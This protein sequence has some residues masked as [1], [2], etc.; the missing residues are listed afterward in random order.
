MLFSEW[1]TRRLDDMGR[2]AASQLART[3]HR[4]PQTVSDYKSGKITPEAW[5]LGQIAAFFHFD[6]TALAEMANRD[7]LEA[8]QAYLEHSWPLA[9]TSSHFLDEAYYQL[10]IAYTLRDRGDPL[11]ALDLL[12][13]WVGYIEER[14]LI[15]Q[16]NTR[17][18]KRRVKDLQA[19]LLRSLNDRMRSMNDVIPKSEIV[20]RTMDDFRLAVRLAQKIGHTREEAR[21]YSLRA[22]AYFVAWRSADA[23]VWV[24]KYL[25]TIGDLP[26]HVPGVRVSLLVPAYL[27]NPVQFEQAE[28]LSL[29]LI[30][31]GKIA[32]A[33][34]LSLLL[35]AMGHGRGLLHLPQADTRLD[36]AQQEFERG[37]A[38]G[39]TLPLRGVQIIRSRLIGETHAEKP[40]LDR[41]QE[42]V[43]AGIKTAREYEYKRHEAELRRLAKELSIVLD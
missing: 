21:A 39:K 34:E 40:N 19:L 41:V 8:Q 11:L 36:A 27:S 22:N 24:D 16:S 37:K 23:A 14:L 33:Q 7:P 35:E 2:G 5:E 1:L 31:G 3:L 12:A 25:A 38:E 13:R 30:D 42:L 28:A 20:D 32:P 6:P 17:Q 43:G 29:D 10:R 4:T 26:P 15:E 9:V 18:D